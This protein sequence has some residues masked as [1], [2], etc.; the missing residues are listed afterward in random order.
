MARSG[1]RYAATN[2]AQPGGGIYQD[3]GGLS[4]EIGDT[5]CAGAFVRTEAGRTGASGRFNVWL[6]GGARNETGGRRYGPLGNFGNWTKVETCVTATTPHSVIR[7]QFYA[8][9]SP[10]P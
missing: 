7:V 9:P 10:R 3:V 5:V 2:A 1:Q 8:V 6:L 4:V